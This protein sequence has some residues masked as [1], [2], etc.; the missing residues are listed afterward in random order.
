MENNGRFIKLGELSISGEDIIALGTSGR[1][2]GN[3]L[4]ALLCDVHFARCENKR[5]ALIIRAKEMIKTGFGN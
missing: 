5:E 1:H 4:Y 3:M 2:I